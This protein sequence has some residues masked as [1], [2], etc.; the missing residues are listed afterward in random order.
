[1]T[2]SLDLET[3]DE[4][5][6]RL[7]LRLPIEEE[8]KRRE[9]ERDRKDVA[10]NADKIRGRCKKSL[11]EF[12]RA[13]WHIVEPDEKK[14]Y[15]HGWHIDAIAQHL[16]AITHGTYLAM[17]LENRLLIN[18]PPGSMKSLIL[19]VF[20]PAWEWG[21]AGQPYHRYV[22][23]S[24]TETLTSRDSRRMRDLV[25]S[26]W[27]QSLWPL[28][29][30]RTGETSFENEHHGWRE[31]SPFTSLTGKRGTRVL[32]DDPHSLDSAESDAERETTL[33]TFREVVPLRLDDPITSAIVVIMQRL[34]EADVSGEIIKLKLPYIRL[35]IAMEFEI[36]DEDACSTPLG[37]VDP[38]TYD[39][40]LMNPE[41]FPRAVV[42]RDKVPL[43]SHATAGQFQQRPVPRGGAM[44][45]RSNCEIIDAIPMGWRRKCRGWDLAGTKRSEGGK[46]RISSH[47]AGVKLS[48][49]PNTGLLL[50]EDVKRG[51]WS[52][53]K[54]EENIKNTATQDGYDTEIDFP[55]DPGQAGKAQVRYLTTKLQGFVVYHSTETGSK[56]QR[57]RP[58]AAQ[59]EVGNVKLLK[60]A[61]NEPFLQELSMFPYGR[62]SD[63]IDALSRAYARLVKKQQ[64]DQGGVAAPI[65][66]KDE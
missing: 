39:G 31:S 2:S 32:I 12:I 28:Q 40:E 49:Y 26:E 15:I 24:Y 14:K 7:L 47:T 46:A 62:M 19:N 42:E 30:I 35:K 57:A 8:I 17:G 34:H 18:V 25:M 4:S 29:M 63:Q 52:P 59:S 11:V 43:G 27:Y 56:P 16:E 55:Q 65:I 10:R 13:A 60:G 45:D 21:P 5:S 50:I 64:G 36:D 1:M 61:W 51:Q 33:R 20:W 37:F 41:R 22:C 3:L 44:F 6:L 53:G 48:Y 54:V 23:T 9:V 38:R 66:V 58:V